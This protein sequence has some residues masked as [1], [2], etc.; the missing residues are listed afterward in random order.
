MVVSAYKN[1]VINHFTLIGDPEYNYQGN[2]VIAIQYRARNVVLNKVRIKNFRK[3]GVDI[4][5]FGGEQRADHV[6]IHNITIQKSAQQAIDIGSG[7]QNIIIN[8]V[9]AVGENGRCGL[10]AGNSQANVSQFHAEGYK[11]PLSIAGKY[12]ETV[13]NTS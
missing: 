2:P 12:K 11:I 1:V 10:K 4:K 8:H 5:V 3:A 6:Y 7:I 9:N 13:S